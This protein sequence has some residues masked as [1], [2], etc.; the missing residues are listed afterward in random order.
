MMTKI[1]KA[2][3]ILAQAI[4]AASA[5][6]ALAAA[7]SALTLALAN[8]PAEG[9][10]SGA[11][12]T[13]EKGDSAQTIALALD[14]KGYIRS[15]LAFRFFAKAEDHG[16]SLKAGTYRILPGMS[17]KQIFDEFVSGE[18][19][20]ARITVP[21]GFSLSQ[22]AGLLER[23]GVTSKTLFLSAARSPELLTELGISAASAEGYLFPDTYF[24]PS[25]YSAEGA[26]RSMVKA[27]RDRLSSIPEAASLTSKELHDRIIL[28][29]IVEREYKVPEEAPL[30]ASV[31]YNRLKIRMA[32]QS[33]ATVV[34]VITERLG[35]PHP[36]VIYDRDLKLDD[37]YNSYEHPGLPPGPIS[38]PGMTALRAVF[39]PDASRFLY[40]RLI[41]ANAGKHHF[42]MSLEEHID[43]RTLFIKKVNS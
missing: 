13:V 39:Y 29:S 1:V 11:L 32:L 15:A 27:F 8:R 35:K 28:A 5:I 33:C 30:I 4:G 23:Q 14:R 31:F 12:F 40:F 41:D 20:L 6:L 18:Q 25:G 19:A 2:R 34:Y 10:G 38:N 24:F 3:R 26:V 16:S 9:I 22:V 43:A 21:E 17:A 42:S 37:P 36:E 7:A